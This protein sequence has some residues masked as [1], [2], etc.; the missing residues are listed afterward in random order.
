MTRSN[1]NQKL[2]EKYVDDGMSHPHDMT[3]TDE[4]RPGHRVLTDVVTDLYD[5][6]TTSIMEVVVRPERDMDTNKLIE[7]EAGRN[8]YDMD[9]EKSIDLLIEKTHS[10]SRAT[11]IRRS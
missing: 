9:M 3:L 4:E 10:V 11:W 8:K 2:S 7:N 1:R 6:S 5:Y